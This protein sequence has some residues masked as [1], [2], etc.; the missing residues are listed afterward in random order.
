MIKSQFRIV[1]TLPLLIRSRTK[2]T[3]GVAVVAFFFFPSLSLSSF[4]VDFDLT[5]YTLAAFIIKTWR[6]DHS[7][8]YSR[9]SLQS[10]SRQCSSG[11]RGV[12]YRSAQ[13]YVPT[14]HVQEKTKAWLPRQV[15]AALIC[16]PKPGKR[17]LRG[18][19]AVRTV[20]VFVLVWADWTLLE[21]DVYWEC[22]D[23]KDDIAWRIRRASATSKH[24]SIELVYTI[25][26]IALSQVPLPFRRRNNTSNTVNAFGMYIDK[27]IDHSS[28][29][30]I[31]PSPQK[32]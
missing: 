19:A 28:L 26:S 13:A 18:V 30:L 8:R 31:P 32:N 10:L 20:R 11:D 16:I 14:Q 21:A 9:D 6:E 5:E 7:L 12:W 23:G 22:G 29:P 1:C 15:A 27:S 4:C 3:H 25:T 2:P 24:S 17:F